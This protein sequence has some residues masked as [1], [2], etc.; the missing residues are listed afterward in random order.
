MSSRDLHHRHPNKRFA[1]ADRRTLRLPH[2]IF[3]RG[4]VE[5]PI[6]FASFEESI[7][8]AQAP[9]TPPPCA[10]THMAATEQES[11]LDSLGRD[12]LRS[13][14]PE[15]EARWED[16]NS[17]LIAVVGADALKRLQAARI[18]VLGMSGLGVEIGALT[19]FVIC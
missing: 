4:R 5:R 10:H 1:F 13:S 17:R 15:D 2:E 14:L 6:N 8:D 9:A 19:A 7:S 3:G 12:A 18:L 11:P 16:A